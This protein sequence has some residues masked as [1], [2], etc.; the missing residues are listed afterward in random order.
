MNAHS[1][2]CS[3]RIYDTVLY[4]DVPASSKKGH[5][6]S[7]TCTRVRPRAVLCLLSV[8]SFLS[9]ACS[10]SEAPSEALALGSARGETFLAYSPESFS[11]P[12]YLP[13]GA[14]MR[15]AAAQLVNASDSA[16]AQDSLSVDIPFYASAMVGE[17]GRSGVRVS[18]LQQMECASAAG[19]M[20]ILDLDRDGAVDIVT[21]SLDGAFYHMNN[22][23]AVFESSVYDPLELRS[24]RSL[25]D[26]IEGRSSEMVI[27]DSHACDLDGDGY[28]ELITVY[29]GSGPRQT[30]PGLVV[31]QRTGP[32][33]PDTEMRISSSLPN[34]GSLGGLTCGDIDGDGNLDMIYTLRYNPR[35]WSDLHSPIRVLLG[36]GAGSFSD[37]T[38][39]W[40]SDYG[41]VFRLLP[42]VSGSGGWP[43][44]PFEPRLAD[45]DGSGRLDLLVS[46]DFGSAVLYR[47]AGK[48][49]VRE[50]SPLEGHY[51]TM[52]VVAL[53]L[54]GDEVLDM[55]VT[56]IDMSRVTTCRW[57][58]T[59]REGLR[60]SGG[61]AVLL[62]GREALLVQADAEDYVSG[63][64]QMGW[65]WGFTTMDLN[66]DGW[67]DVFQ[68][69]GSSAA[70]VNEESFAGLYTGQPVAVLMGG[71]AGFADRTREWSEV[72][73]SVGSSM[74]VASADVDGDGTPD[75]I[76]Y[77]EGSRY[78]QIYLNR[79]SPGAFAS[80]HVTSPA[81]VTMYRGSRASETFRLPDRHG[82]F[83]VTADAPWF[84]GAD[85]DGTRLEVVFDS[86]PSKVLTFFPG[87]HAK[88]LP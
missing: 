31:V 19:H 85:A 70:F 56:D 55:M 6:V 60:S 21:S 77:S 76:L 48:S 88:V 42:T 36:D 26:F 53:D 23:A 50:D 16:A 40:V 78:P 68:A 43:I 3:C 79:S 72:W 41:R 20:A 46:A 4:R 87:D 11:E 51:S 80:L 9:G 59:C 45:L 27:S 7:A 67:W 57:S 47:N 63:F 18:V 66:G 29:S 71:P 24:G 35:D 5:L 1:P 65:G 13:F 12:P 69:S 86:G 73:G 37:A 75:L 64:S 28:S 17:M 74:S 83:Q 15:D 32:S 22:G 62:G 44:L 30:A 2:C 34:Y 25:I 14:C 84:F 8:L 58:S 49:F 61:N 52:G 82:S 38:S 39:S 33:W 54:D 81:T 10:S